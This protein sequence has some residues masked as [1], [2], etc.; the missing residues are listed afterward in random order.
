[1]PSCPALDQL[2]LLALLACA[3]AA[4]ALSRY[5]LAGAIN[6][7]TGG[8]FPWGIFVTN[9]LGCFLFGLIW[10]LGAVRGLFSEAVR[11]VL[12]T[13]FVGAFTT[14]STLVFDLY[15]LERLGQWLSLAANLCGQLVLGFAALR[16][17]MW[18]VR[19]V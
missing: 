17:G 13:G 8:P 9:V 2:R 19:L 3:G 4:G 15:L 7:L 6:S 14:F 5:L 18:L 10:E 1:M 11:T 16:L 12:A